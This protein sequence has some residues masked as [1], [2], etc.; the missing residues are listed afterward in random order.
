M[1][2]THTAPAGQYGGRDWGSPHRYTPV[3]IRTHVYGLGHGPETQS[4]TRMSPA[5]RAPSREASAPPSAPPSVPPSMPASLPASTPASAPPSG[6]PP[7][8]PPP[9][10]PQFRALKRLHA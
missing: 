8:R 1:H 3:P 7:S 2:S 4:M 6:A 10:G 9:S 5:S